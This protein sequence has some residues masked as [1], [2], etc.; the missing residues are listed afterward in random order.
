MPYND[1]L[2]RCPASLLIAIAIVLS[3]AVAEASEANP[4]PNILW[5]TCEDISPH[6]GCYGDS[7][8]KTPTLD[9]LA[10]QGVRYSHAFATASV[11][12][13]VRSGLITG[14]YASSLGTQ[15]LRGP[16]RLPKQIRCFTEYLRESGYYC[17]N[18]VKED[19]NFATPPAAWDESSGKA[20]WRGRKPGQPFFS[21]FN[22]TTT[23]QSQVRLPPAQFAQRT[24]RLSPDERHDPADAPLP[25]YYPDTPIVRRDVAHLYDLITAM[26][27]QVA[28]LLGQLEEDGLADSTIVFFY[29]DHGTGMP[30][31]KRWLYDSG[32]RVPLMIRFP[33]TMQRLAP[34]K[35]GTTVGRLVSFLDFAPTVLRLAGLEIPE[36]MQGE[37]FLVDRTAKPRDYVFAIRDR[38]D[39][40]YEMSRTVR[41]ER[42]RYIR[43]FVPHRARMQHSDY[44][45]RTPTRQE[46]RRL[47]AAGQLQGPPKDFMSPTKS[48]EELYDTVNDPHEIHNLA[49]SA[50]HRKILSRMRDALHDWMIRTRDTGL[51]PEAHMHALSADR[52]PYEMAQDPGAFPVARILEVAELVGRDSTGKE[53]T[54][55]DRLTAGLTDTEPAVRY[56][57][58][59]GLRSLGSRAKPASARLIDTLDDETPDVRIA[60]AE[61]LCM[62]GSEEEGL[63]VLAEE[64]RHDDSCVRLQAAMT[65]AAIG[66][67]AQGIAEQIRKALA[68]E[69]KGP[70]SGYTRWALAYALKNV[71]Q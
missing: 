5:I 30:R 63:S 34:D 9:R 37:P 13:P 58:A 32:T 18:N 48:P 40:V 3:A 71:E 23:H 52:S 39:E 66:K 8:A 12:T 24:A 16:A 7:Y 64:L 44:S 51:L 20:H 35:P 46:F 10:R 28:D 68:E 61:A 47:A 45:E 43:N 4:R 26:D 67:R 2:R 14:M 6:L 50:E 27:K 36:T 38:V 41:D 22:F 56:W 49:D 54:P 55:L 31:H 15:H 70:H 1:S 53:P 69:G 42:Y 65:L 60:A 59:I 25:P 11:C 62:T 29:S 21:I 33:A 57:A 19:Y 17:S